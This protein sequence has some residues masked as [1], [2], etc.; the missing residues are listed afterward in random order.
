VGLPVLTKDNLLGI[1]VAEADIGLSVGKVENLEK[2]LGECSDQTDLAF[3]ACSR[4]SGGLSF[5]Y[6]DFLRLVCGGVLLRLTVE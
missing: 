3:D 5:S 6:A 1:D 4:T 2:L